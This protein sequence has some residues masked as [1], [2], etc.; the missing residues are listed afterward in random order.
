MNT[1]ISVFALL[2]LAAATQHLVAWAG[3]VISS[4]ATEGARYA[5]FTFRDDRY[6]PMTTNILMNV[7]IPNVVMVFIFMAARQFDWKPVEQYLWV[8]GAAFFAYRFLLIC[9]FLRRKEMYT[10]RYELGMAGAG[11]LLSWFLRRTFF[12]GEETVFITASELRE[13]LWIAIIVILYQFVK[14]IV[15]KKV[16]QNRVLTKG[17]ISKYIIHKFNLFAKRY[18][19]LLEVTAESRYLCILLYAVMIFEDYNRGPL[20]RRLERI[21]A[22]FT[23]K[24]TTG[25]MQMASDKPLSD[26]E[27][28]ILFY[29]W[30]EQQAGAYTQFNQDDFFIKDVAWNHNN[31]DDYAKSVTY[32]YHVLYDYIDQVP[33]YRKQFF[34]REPAT[35]AVG[36]TE[37]EN[38]GAND[39]DESCQAV[40]GAAEAAAAC[41][42]GEAI[43]ICQDDRWAEEK[44]RFKEDTFKRAA[45]CTASNLSSFF[46]NLQDHMYLELTKG[47]YELG[48]ELRSDK[49]HFCRVPGGKELHIRNLEHVCLEGNG[50]KLS[51]RAGHADVLCFQDCRHVTLRHWRIGHASRM[52]EGAGVVLRFENCS[53]IR[54]ENVDVYGGTYGILCTGGNLLVRG[55]R[56]HHCTYGAVLLDQAHCE[57]ERVLIKKNTLEGGVI[58]AYSSNIFMQNVRISE[59]QSQDFIL[60]LEESGSVC[61]QVTAD[62]NIC[63]GISNT[64]DLPGVTAEKNRIAAAG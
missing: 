8:Y 27:S 40:W 2:I 13:E 43:G 37:G 5:V 63:V 26:T 30:L 61:R 62:N 12:V 28:V 21:K 25:I 48:E 64:G 45:A 35:D 57:M 51:A 42:D 38:G 20:V 19:G 46:E 4:I 52:G 3:S 18:G 14:M 7:C 47:T 59:N 31:D 9:V 24:A 36:P 23:K 16:T 32:I 54:L 55:S 6:M 11:L 1:V 41:E 34:L 17:Q 15:D 29:N 49:L 22:R 50:S 44:N 39:T 10:W 60:R 58:N 33:R 53:E 56:I